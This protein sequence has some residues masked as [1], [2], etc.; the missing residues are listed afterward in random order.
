MVWVS[1]CG[2]LCIRGAVFAT[3]LDSYIKN[4]FVGIYL[5]PHLN[6]ATFSKA[7]LPLL[8]YYHVP[9]ILMTR[10]GYVDLINVLCVRPT[11]VLTYNGVSVFLY[12]IYVF[13][14]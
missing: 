2:T 4:K 11:S 6:F 13:V 1:S 8:I 9:C 3:N 10:R 12:D 7:L 5:S 14:H